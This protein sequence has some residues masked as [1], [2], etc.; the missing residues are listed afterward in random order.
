MHRERALE[1]EPRFVNTIE[2]ECQLAQKV[3][4]VPEAERA[5][6]H[7]NIDLSIRHELRIE[8]AAEVELSERHR[9]LSRKRCRLFL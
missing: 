5:M 9:G 7:H 2:R 4:Q 3:F 8:R 1:M 6:P